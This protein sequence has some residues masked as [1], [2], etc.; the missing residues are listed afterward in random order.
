MFQKILVP[1]DGSRAA[2]AAL[3]LACALAALS[4]GELEL[5]RC[6]LL[7]ED[8]GYPIAVPQLVMDGERQHCEAYLMNQVDQLKQTGLTCDFQVLDGG[9][10]ARRILEEAEHGHF[11]LIVL[12]SHG[13][14]GLAHLM[15]GSVAEK[16]SRHAGCP[17]LIVRGTDLDHSDLSRPRLP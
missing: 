10:A 5:V 2:E 7:P 14:T 17:V 12:T 13:R 1:L 3:P 4:H 11:D 9:N 8:M 6:T 15:L 16:V